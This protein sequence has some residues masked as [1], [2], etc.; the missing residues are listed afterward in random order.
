MAAVAAGRA[1]VVAGPA[2]AGAVEAAEEVL[3]AAAGATGSVAAVTATGWV[4]VCP[5]AA[6]EATATAEGVE[7]ELGKAEAAARGLWRAPWSARRRCWHRH[8]ARFA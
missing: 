4:A 2:W 6:A 1:T 3:V 5:V 8:R 7:G